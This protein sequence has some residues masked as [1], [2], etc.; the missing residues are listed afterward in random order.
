MLEIRRRVSPEGRVRTRDTQIRV[1]IGGPMHH[2]SRALATARIDD[3]LRDA[4]QMHMIRLARRVTH[5]AHVAASNVADNDAIAGIAPVAHAH[6][7]SLGRYDLNRQ[8]PAAGQLR[9]L[10]LVEDIDRVG[11][12]P[13][14]G[15]SGDKH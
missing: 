8:P 15:V 4:A 5:E 12:T 13:P 6:V 10:R 14:L 7:N 3:L 1:L 11:P 9:P 2:L